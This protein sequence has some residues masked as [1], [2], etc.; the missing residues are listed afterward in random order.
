M[1]IVDQLRKD[2][3]QM[4][5]L[6]LIVLVGLSVLLAG[7]WWVQVVR[8]RTYQASLE[9]QSYRTVR[10]PAVRGR[11]LD[12]HGVVLAENR[13]VYNLSLY[14]E[15]LRGAFDTEYSRHLGRKREQLKRE[16]EAAAARLGRELTKAEKKQFTLSLK[17]RNELRAAARLAV[18]SNL[19]QQI[20]VTL[21]KPIAFDPAEFD[22]HY[23]TRLALPYPLLRNLEPGQIALLQEEPHRPKGVDLEVQSIRVYPF[24]TLASHVLG[25]LQRDDRSAEGE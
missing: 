11:L 2:D 4:R 5:G 21:G 23:A 20:G 19:V 17:D 1:L 7:L 3:P 13:P 6:T 15:E 8:G 18:A 9:T 16:S 22:R 24:F 25:R 14:L 10:I 12:R